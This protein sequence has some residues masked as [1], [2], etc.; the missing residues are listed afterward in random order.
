MSR[1]LDR[2]EAVADRAGGAADLRADVLDVLREAI[3]FDGYVWLLTDPVTTVG[4]A[5][6]ADLPG[7]DPAELPGL[8]RAKYTRR[9]PR[10]A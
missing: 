6:L 8:I 9:P 5:P 7:I 10:L 3:E 1:T 4:A 2:I